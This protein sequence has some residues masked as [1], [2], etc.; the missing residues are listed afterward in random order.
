MPRTHN[1]FYG[2]GIRKFGDRSGIESYSINVFATGAVYSIMDQSFKRL[3]P[4]DEIG[5]VGFKKETKLL[6]E[7]SKWHSWIGWT[8]HFWGISDLGEI[9][10]SAAHWLCEYLLSEDKA[11]L[12]LI[13]IWS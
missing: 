4:T 3:R 5:I 1:G 2:G 7:V 10:E 13:E 6:K 9:M 8:S 12:E 11:Y